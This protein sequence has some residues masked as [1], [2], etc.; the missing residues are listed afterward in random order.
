MIFSLFVLYHS[1]NNSD[2]ICIQ[3]S[4]PHTRLHHTPV[5]ETTSMYCTAMCQIIPDKCLKEEPSLYVTLA[6]IANGERSKKGQIEG[7][8]KGEG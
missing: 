8:K 3:D 1:Y 4:G 2:N 7:K 6:N 5:I